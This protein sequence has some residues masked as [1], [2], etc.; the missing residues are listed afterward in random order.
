MELP[1][2]RKKRFVS[3]YGITEDQASFLTD[4]RESADFFEKSTGL[5]ADPVTAA[6]WL[7]SDIQRICNRDAVVLT[8]SML[9]EERFASFISLIHE[10][11]INSKIGKELAELL[12]TDSRDPETIIRE[13]GWEQIGDKGEIE[14]FV[15]EVIGENQKAVEQISSGDMKPIGFLVGQ[16]MKK[17]KGKADPRMAQEIIK[18]KLNI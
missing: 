3:E 4:D 5:G 17:S 7:G 2:I 10:G 12:F 1:Q 15:T 6:A 13:E 8:D 9:T 18:E 11:R 16:V 14:G